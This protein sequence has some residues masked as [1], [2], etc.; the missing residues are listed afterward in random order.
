MELHQAPHGDGQGASRVRARGRWVHVLARLPVHL[1]LQPVSALLEAGRA[2][3]RRGSESAD[4]ALP[5]VQ[6]KPGA[7]QVRRA[8][9]HRLPQRVQS[10][11]L[12]CRVGTPGADANAAVRRRGWTAQPLGGGA[13]A[14]AGRWHRLGSSIC[15]T[16]RLPVSSWEHHCTVVS[17]FRM[18]IP[19]DEYVQRLHV[20]MYKVVAVQTV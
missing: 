5:P 19:A 13:P 2:A 17:D 11:P 18:A 3:L 9:D 14:E 15:S 4:R 16:I 20:P 8:P 6:R 7:S 10:H 12:V 1:R